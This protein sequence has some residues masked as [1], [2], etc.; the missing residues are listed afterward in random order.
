MKRHLGMHL[1]RYLTKFKMLRSSEADELV[2]CSFSNLRDT[3]KNVPHHLLWNS[4]C[5][6]NSLGRDIS[7]KCEIVNLSEAEF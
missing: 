1:Y 3:I 4:R 7:K 6:H 5:Y 2:S